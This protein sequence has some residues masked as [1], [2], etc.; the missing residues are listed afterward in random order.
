VSNQ[1]AVSAIECTQK[2]DLLVHIITNRQN[3]LILKG[4]RG[5][6]KS[7]FLKTVLK[8]KTNKHELYLIKAND[9]MSFEVVQAE[10]LRIISASYQLDAH[11][12]IADVLEIY[13]KEGKSLILLIDDAGCLISGVIST[14]ITY[15]NQHKA[16]RLVFALTPSEYDEK[17]KIEKI[18]SSCQIMVLPGLTQKQTELLIDQLVASGNTAYATKE[19]D[20]TFVQKI[21]NITQGN[22]H[23]IKR[24]ILLTKKNNLNHLMMIIGAVL[25]VA[26]FSIVINSYLWSEPEQ[27]QKKELTTHNDTVAKLKVPRSMEQHTLKQVQKITSITLKQKGTDA[28][29]LKK[30]VLPAG[31]EIK[32]SSVIVSGVLEP[33][34]RIAMHGG[35]SPAV[36]VANELE[37]KVKPTLLVAKVVT[38]DENHQFKSYQAPV[39]ENN[40]QWILTQ[41]GTD[42]TLQLM[43]LSAKEKLLAVQKK[44]LKLGYKTFHI[45]KN[46]KKT[47]SYI[48]FYGHFATLTEA[49]MQAKKLPKELRKAWPRKLSV[50]QK[51]IQSNISVN[52]REGEKRK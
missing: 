41:K 28:S 9:K 24:L 10:I 50:I 48:L 40:Y 45:T 25:M 33:K 49:K 52:I 42:Y 37:K 26:L 16:L 43:A 22:P 32:S 29:V 13:A 4:K 39:L 11:H 17:Q 15:A 31:E 23:E 14:L 2:L 6:G 19:V 12:S 34:E 36:K 21:Y 5:V 47:L 3:C 35:D 7:T 1:G 18:E 51:Q 20:A 8:R 27:K 30:T 46:T 38:L 44:Y